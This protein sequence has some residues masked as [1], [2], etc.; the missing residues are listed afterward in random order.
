MDLTVSCR[1]VCYRYDETNSTIVKRG[2]FLSPTTWIDSVNPT[3]GKW[4]TEKECY[5]HVWCTVVTI[6]WW[7][8]INP[9]RSTKSCTGR[10][11][12]ARTHFSYARD[13]PHPHAMVLVSCELPSSAFLTSS[14]SHND[15]PSLPPSPLLSISEQHLRIHS[16]AVVNALQRYS[17]A[18]T[19]C[20]I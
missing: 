12:L 4:E 17:K 14:P 19:N 1:Y 9:R 13:Y 5:W 16:Q 15:N 8:V 6:R 7:P 18:D 10:C 20:H 2:Y 3:D 11:L